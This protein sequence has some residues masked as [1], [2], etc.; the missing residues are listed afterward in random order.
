MKFKLFGTK[1][2]VSFA[3]SL[4]LALLIFFDRTGLAVP[5]LFAAAFH[6]LSHLF[7]MWLLGLSPTE[8]NLIPG[9]VQ[10][11]SRFP[12]G[13][14]KSVLVSLAGPFANLTVFLA[15][16]THSAVFG[17]NKYLEVSVINLVFALFNLLPLKGLDGGEILTVLLAEKTGYEKAEKIIAFITAVTGA[18]AVITGIAL[19]LRGEMNFSVII[20]GIYLTVSAL[21]RI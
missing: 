2:Y 16:F 19:I 3:F 4:I 14:V 15:L 18:A 12:A 17:D 9:S 11:V 7:A 10:I 5:M 13:N 8:I 20:I 21:L 1:V 6:E